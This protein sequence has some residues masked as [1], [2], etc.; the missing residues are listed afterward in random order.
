LGS[1]PPNL[2]VFD[3]YD[4]VYRTD[5]ENIYR[6]FMRKPDSDESYSSYASWRTHQMSDHLPMWVE[7]HID[8][9]HEYL[10][11]VEADIQSELND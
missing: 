11:E 9:A 10:D 3:F 2:G 7:L 1:N 4:I 5:E 8:F 6:P